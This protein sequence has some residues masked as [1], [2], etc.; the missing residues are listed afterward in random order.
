[1]KKTLPRKIL[2]KVWEG[3]T[4]GRQKGQL[5]GT[6]RRRLSWCWSLLPTKMATGLL[7]SGQGKSR[8]AC[9]GGRFLDTER[10]V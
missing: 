6:E 3:R 10:E 1:M 8:W 9:T 2:E 5:A 4:R 7:E